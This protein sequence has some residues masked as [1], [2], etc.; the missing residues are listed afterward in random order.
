MSIDERNLHQK[1]IKHISKSAAEKFTLILIS[2]RRRS[3]KNRPMDKI[4]ID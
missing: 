1:G 3:L 2:L 4:F